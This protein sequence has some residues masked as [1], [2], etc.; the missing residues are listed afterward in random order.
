MEIVLTKNRR[1]TFH[2][3]HSDLVSLMIKHFNSWPF[4]RTKANRKVL[5]PRKFSLYFVSISSMTRNNLRF[6][7]PARWTAAFLAIAIVMLF[8]VT[9]FLSIFPNHIGVSAHQEGNRR[10]QQTLKHIN[11]L[12]NIDVLSHFIF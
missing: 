8:D 6:V 2:S 3:Y 1:T 7:C 10:R 11:S 9:N 5:T 4:T 12:I